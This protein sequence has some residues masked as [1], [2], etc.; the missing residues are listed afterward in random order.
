M[1]PA[2]PRSNLERVIQAGIDAALKELHT[3]LPGEVVSF[4]PAEQTA[5]IQIAIKRKQSGELVNIPVLRDVPVRFQRV[6]GYTITLPVKPGDNVLVIF[7][8]RSIDT[9]LASGG[10]QDPADKRKHSFSDAFAF[11][12]MYAQPDKISDFDPDNLQIKSLNGKAKITVKLSG[13][14]QIDTTGE[15]IINSSKTKINNDVDIDGDLKVTGTT[16]S[17]G[18]LTGQTGLAVSG[19]HPSTG[20]GGS[21]SGDMV[22]TGGDVK[23][24]GVGLKT[25]TH[26]QGNDS[27]GDGQVAT[28]VGA[29]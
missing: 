27:A 13:E 9:W 18:A 24:D 29:G 3:S 23:A 11:P 5:D 28:N 10:I 26:T 20:Q 7:S 17:I 22:I 2:D 14:I 16:L 8:E 25:H 21:V 12:M 15:T 1:A 6:S 19:V 4:D